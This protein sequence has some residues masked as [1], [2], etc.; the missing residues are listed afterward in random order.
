LSNGKKKSEDRIE[1]QVK[2][3]DSKNLRNSHRVNGDFMLKN[4]FIRVLS[5]Y[6]NKS[7]NTSF[8]VIPKCSATFFNILFKV[9]IFNALCAGIVM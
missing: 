2:N 6:S 9:P 8:F 3:V 4:E 7:F 5:N 1:K